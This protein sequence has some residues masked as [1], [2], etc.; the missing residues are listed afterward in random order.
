MIRSSAAEFGPI[1]I[2]PGMLT[3]GCYGRVVRL[4]KVRPS[5]VAAVAAICTGVGMTVL[6]GC[7]DDGRHASTESAGSTSGV[8]TSTTRIAGAG[9]L[10]NQRRPDE[11]CAAEPARLDGA[12]NVPDPQRIVVLAGDEL[13]ALCALGL[14]SRIVAAALPDGATA[15]PSYL[16]GAVHG[17]PGAGS[18]TAPDLNAIAAAKPDLILGS[19]ALTPQAYTALAAIAPT[20]FTDSAGASWQDNVRKVGTATGRSDAATALVDQFNDRAKQIGST[21]DAAHFQASIVQFTDSVVRVYGSDN[22]PAS[23]LNDA[24]VDRPAS[25]RFTDKPYIEVGISDADLD[26]IPDLS[27]A[28]GDIVYLSFASQ[29]AKERAPKVLESAAWRKLSATR[30]NRVFIVN[31]EI[32]QSGQGLIAAGAI[33]DDLHWLNAP[34]N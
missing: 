17:L 24:G 8:I 33:L 12:P 5:A 28:D 1:E 13:D 32:W 27:A 16:G 31:N 19:Q 4:P 18:R 14:Q 22:F 15:Q 7:S 25:Q 2:D 26:R 9:V 34:I 11:S 30:D 20:V 29:Q 10:G 21:I 3:H 6:S 23:V